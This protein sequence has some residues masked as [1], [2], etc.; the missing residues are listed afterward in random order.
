MPEPIT[1]DLA[2]FV[3]HRGSRGIVLEVRQLTDGVFEVATMVPG[4]GAKQ[5]GTLTV[6]EL[7]DLARRLQKAASFAMAHRWEAL[8]VF[9]GRNGLAQILDDVR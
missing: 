7:F 5:G 6:E 9:P 2:P 8:P 3:P 1:T 4:H